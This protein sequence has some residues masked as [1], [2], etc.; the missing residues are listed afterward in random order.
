MALV[1]KNGSTLIISVKRKGA[2]FDKRTIPNEYLYEIKVSIS[3]LYVRCIFCFYYQR[4]QI[5][6]KH[7]SER[8]LSRLALSN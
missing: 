1:F 4:K 8:A 5:K 7:K 2:K 6:Q 3:N